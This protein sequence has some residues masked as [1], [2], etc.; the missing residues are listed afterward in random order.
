MDVEACKQ[1]VNCEWGDWDYEPC[2]VTCGVGTHMGIRKEMVQASNVGKPCTGPSQKIQKCSTSVGCPTDCKWGEWEYDSCSV[3]CGDGTKRGIRR[4]MVQ[5][6]NGGKPCIGSS[7]NTQP[8]RSGVSC[9]SPTD[10]KWGEWE[11]ESCSVTC[12]KGTKLGI[13]RVVEQASNGGRPC[14]G[15]SLETQP[16]SSGISCPGIYFWYCERRHL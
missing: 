3:T 10:C 12:G 7:L 15:P 8:C 1:P 16:C 5:A 6:S 11:Y 13:R 2:S 4:V 14:E 9:P